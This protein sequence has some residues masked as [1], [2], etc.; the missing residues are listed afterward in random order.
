MVMNDNYDIEANC[1]NGVG[2]L[3]KIGYMYLVLSE[4][5]AMKIVEEVSSCLEQ[6]QSLKAEASKE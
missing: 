2:I 6:M 5:E 4:S 1:H 3:L